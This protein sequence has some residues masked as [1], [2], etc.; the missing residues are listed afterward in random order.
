MHKIQNK[1]E[2]TDRGRQDNQME[3]QNNHLRG[4]WKQNIRTVGFGI[5]L[6][7]TALK[8]PLL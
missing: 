8:K 7:I 4:F 3:K 1:R 5:S 2:D 6:K